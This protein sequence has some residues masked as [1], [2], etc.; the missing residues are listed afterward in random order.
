[1]ADGDELDRWAYRCLP[2]K[3]TLTAADARLVEEA[4][5]IKLTGF[6]GSDASAIQAPSE[7]P[8]SN[9]LVSPEDSLRAQQSDGALSPGI[10]K[11]LLTFPEPRRLRDKIH[12]RFVAKQPCLI[13]G[14]QPCDAH[15]L[16][17]A[18]SRGLG[19]KVSDEFTVPLCRGHHRELH[20]SSIEA[21]WWKET[22]VDA[23]AIARKLWNETH[24]IPASTCTEDAI[25]P[26]APAIVV[27]KDRLDPRPRRTQKTQTTKR[28]QIPSPST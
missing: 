6:G 27:E 19:L 13:C 18:Q 7:A 15:H 9:Q 5:Q 8:A 12:L 28:T 21:N 23:T 14:R 11:S 25:V 2:T 20:R 22:G 26:P 17:F 24:P 3:N 1:L 16:R 4:F 10:D